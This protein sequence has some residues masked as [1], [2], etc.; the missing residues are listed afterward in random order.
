[1]YICYECSLV[2]GVYNDY[3]RNAESIRF[4]T[5][6]VCGLS[7]QT[8]SVPRANV[9]H[10][11]VVETKKGAYCTCGKPLLFDRTL[12]GTPVFKPCLCKV[13]EVNSFIANYIRKIEKEN[14][15]N[16]SSL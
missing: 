4:S 16:G 1:M 3:W 7:R 14:D 10:F 9:G 6:E 2:K 8:R 5:C 11:K 13:K 15:D 12:N